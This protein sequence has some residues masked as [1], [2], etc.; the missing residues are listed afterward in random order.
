ML[1]YL[2]KFGRNGAAVKLFLET[3]S[4][5]VAV[6]LSCGEERVVQA[7]KRCVLRAADVDLVQLQALAAAHNA[8][9]EFF[10]KP[11]TESMVLQREHPP[12]SNTTWL[13]ATIR[14]V[15]AKLNDAKEKY[16]AW[17][18]VRDVD[19]A[20]ENHK[21]RVDEIFDL[22]KKIISKAGENAFVIG[23][24]YRSLPFQATERFRLG[25]LRDQA[26]ERAS[27][28]KTRLDF[29][30]RT[31]IKELETKVRDLREE[32]D[33]DRKATKQHG[34]RVRE[35]LDNTTAVA[36]IVTVRSSSVVGR[37]RVGPSVRDAV[38]DV[39][40]RHNALARRLEQVRATLETADDWLALSPTWGHAEPSAFAAAVEQAFGLVPSAAFQKQAAKAIEALLGAYPPRL[41]LPDLSRF[42][43]LAAGRRLAYLGYALDLRAAQTE[44]PVFFD[45]DE[46]GPRHVAVVGGSGSGKS[47]AASLLLEGA[48][49]HG[50]G[51]LVLDPTGS[52]TGFASPCTSSR[53][54]A[55]YPRFHMRPEWARAFDVRIVETADQ[56]DV[57][58]LA[59]E[60]R[61]TILT[62][63]KLSEAEEVVTATTLLNQLYDEMSSQPDSPRLRLLLVLE[64]AHRYLRAKEVQP[65]LEKFARMARKKGVGLLVVSQVMVDLPPAI[66]N[67]TSTK[68][69]LNTHYA[70][71]LNRAAQIFGSEF[72]KTIPKLT[73]G[74][75]AY[76]FPEHGTALVAFRP[77]MHSPYAASKDAVA[78]FTAS[79]ELADSVAHLLA[80]PD[81]TD[82]TPS[83]TVTPGKRTAAPPV[84]EPAQPTKATTWRDIAT[85]VAS[86]GERPSVH[87]LAEAIG[88]EGL[89]PPSLRT[90]QRFARSF[91]ANG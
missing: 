16:E 13:E 58:N 53:L 67:N 6:V 56:A 69:L 44:L 5:I 37:G 7:F 81:A 59:R 47:V 31:R 78:A 4:Q 24:H 35:R 17:R 46:Q 73:Q 76:H 48:L 39:R 50:I 27:A 9:L 43:K 84:A 71:D 90:L 14:H 66:R 28:L 42:P 45:L 32:L 77:P 86:R 85:R 52:W 26:K 70:E 23:D 64:E 55:G 3:R 57:P 40:L 63:A 12:A 68:I 34:E 22:E 72:Q 11:P 74:T 75:G 25:E 49:L 91:T 80:R 54:L 15:L 83:D 29:T 36:L 20:R 89:Q 30:Y 88:K 19:E 21:R 79:R 33:H 2:G 18:G 61:V 41:A 82:D 38:E 1:T 62:S 51:A 60:G 65:V 10:T 87:E 8:S